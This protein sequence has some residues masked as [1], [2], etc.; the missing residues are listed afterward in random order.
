[1][2]AISLRMT[3]KHMQLSNNASLD[4]W[5]ESCVMMGVVPGY[6]VAVPHADIHAT[7]CRLARD[8]PSVTVRR[9]VKDPESP[10]PYLYKIRRVSE[11]SNKWRQWE[12]GRPV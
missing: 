12:D 9:I 3:N 7:V 10:Y 4:E 6:G 2:A 11:F 1:M 8:R 5:Q